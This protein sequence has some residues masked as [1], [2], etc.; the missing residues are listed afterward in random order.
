MT[1]DISVYILRDPRTK[2][3][4]YVGMSKNPATRLVMHK[5]TARSARDGKKKIVMN[6]LR[7]W[8]AELESAGLEPIVEVVLSTPDFRLARYVE[9]ACQFHLQ[10]EILNEQIG[11][12]APLLSAPPYIGAGIAE[13]VMNMT[14]DLA[15]DLYSWID[16]HPKATATDLADLVSNDLNDIGATLERV[17]RNHRA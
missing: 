3:R 11:N 8:I 4:L 6:R 13:Y 7:T 9:S 12:P 17:L 10:R 2:K 5:T 15:R 14:R 1:G 16:K